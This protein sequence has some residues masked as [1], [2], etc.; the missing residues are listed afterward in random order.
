MKP[1][2]SSPS[3]KHEV[4]E[5]DPPKKILAKLRAIDAEI[6]RDLNELEKMP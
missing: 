6:S 4:V 1:T 2:P 3:A 5:Y